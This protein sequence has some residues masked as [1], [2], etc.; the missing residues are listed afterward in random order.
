AKEDDLIVQRAAEVAAPADLER[1]LRRGADRA[2]AVR[3]LEHRRLAERLAVEHLERRIAGR[4]EH[5][6]EARVEGAAVPLVLVVAR[7]ERRDDAALAQLQ[8]RLAVCA[9]FPTAMLRWS[10]LRLHGRIASLRPR[11]R[12]RHDVRALVRHAAG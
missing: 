6:A 1:R 3:D 2:V 5:H 12:G 8:L 4:L 7:A 11:K 9:P 10:I